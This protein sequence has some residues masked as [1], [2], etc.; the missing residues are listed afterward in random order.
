MQIIVTGAS[1]G[2]TRVLHIGGWQLLAVVVLAAALVLALAA[3]A[4]RLLAPPAGPAGGPRAGLAL[5]PAGEEVA[6]RDRYLRENLDAIAERLG[7]LQAKLLRLD[8][9]GARVSS[10]A[11]LKPEDLVAL[12]REPAAD[13]AAVRRTAAS[14]ARAGAAPAVGASVGR[15]SG[16]ALHADRL[17]GSD[18]A[19]GSPP[20]AA[21]STGEGGPYLPMATPSLAQLH[22]ALEA[23][24]ADAEQH[25]DVLT[26]AESRLMESRLHARMLPSSAPVAGPVG[27]AFGFRLDPFT[28]R[29]ALHTGLDFPAPAGTPI[30][31]AA[32]GVV[33]SAETHP[34]YGQMVEIDHGNRLVTR[35][36][37]A[38]RLLVR[39][40]DIVRRGQPIAAVGSTGRSTGPHLHFEVLQDGVR[41]NPARFL[42]RQAAPR[43]A[44][45]R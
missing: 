40:G 24:E 36:A 38:S 30:E 6:R 33:V 10:L 15:G 18:G 35:Y 32:G 31:A 12:E 27:S 26:L 39:P 13:A 3:G 41:Q 7:T 21:S 25:G 14:A 8:A 17:P 19:A 29:A 45:A 20:A 2:R 11:G 37:H 5:R 23:L 28:G 34:A 4:V 22:A 44:S 42:A 16:G 9:V 43:L 1:P